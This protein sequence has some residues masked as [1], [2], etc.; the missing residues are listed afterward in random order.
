LRAAL[1]VAALH[2]I[3]SASNL[4]RAL[5]IALSPRTGEIEP[6]AMRRALVGG[7]DEAISLVGDGE[8]DLL[9]FAEFAAFAKVI[10]F[11][12]SPLDLQSLA[13]I[14]AGTSAIGTGGALGYLVV[15]GAASP[16]LLLSVPAGI[17]LCA[18]AYGVAQGLQPALKYRIMALMGMPEALIRKEMTE[19]R[20]RRRGGG[21]A[22]EQDY[23]VEAG[24]EGPP[25]ASA[26]R[27]R[28]SRR[29]SM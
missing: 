19:S 28:R 24:S 11:T 2:E 5:A 10:P 26:P 27:A 6:T 16:L 8:S 4:A 22:A 17:V 1:G 13:A 9:P 7:Q 23:E 20:S 21:E 12:E 15:A 3:D 18:A 29:Y 14:F 25:P